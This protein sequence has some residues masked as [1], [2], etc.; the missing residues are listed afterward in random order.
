M[1]FNY[2]KDIEYAKKILELT[3][4]DIC[5]ML[6]ISRMTYYRWISE[7]VIPSPEN[8]EK[9]YCTLHDKRVKINPLKEEMYK[10]RE[11]GSKRI[12]YHGAKN[13]IEGEITIEKSEP[14]KDFGK[15]F[16]M[17]ETLLQSASF[18]SNYPNSSVYVFECQLS[19]DLKI[20]EYDV[21]HEWIILISYFRG[22]IDD[23]KNSKYLKKLLDEIKDVD[24]IVA[25][26]ADN[27][28]YDILDDF[29]AGEITDLQCLNALSANWLGKQ[30]VFLNDAAI[31]KSLTII[32]RLYLC[33]QEK[34]DYKTKKEENTII[35]KQKVKL[36][37]REFAGKG[38]YI[39]ELLK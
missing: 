4:E 33:K 25:P 17:G 39:E 1:T 22:K 38:K 14:K 27:T 18:V 28:M 24:I 7:K 29:S 20:K 34:D 35:G 32:D 3:D 8:L 10:A 5:K 23:Y 2:I 21:T 26:I 12:L 30:Y 13:F 16:Y 11:T 37:K 6:E 31:K 19:K 9:L 36:A 15:G